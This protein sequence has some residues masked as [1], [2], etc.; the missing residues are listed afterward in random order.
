MAPTSLAWGWSY[1]TAGESNH[2]L[3]CLLYFVA[4]RV[5]RTRKINGKA[6]PYVCYD[7][8]ELFAVEDCDPSGWRPNPQITEE[9]YLKFLNLFGGALDRMK[10]QDPVIK[11]EMERLADLWSKLD[12]V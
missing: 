8:Q 11:R 6:K 5:G 10:R 3:W 7:G 1:S 4:L 12:K 2:Y 9:L